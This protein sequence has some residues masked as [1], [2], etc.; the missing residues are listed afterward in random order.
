[1]TFLTE[2]SFHGAICFYCLL[3]AEPRR[4]PGLS[5]F[6]GSSGEKNRK[7]VKK[8]LLGVVY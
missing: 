7:G 3:F 8:R 5:F 2:S 1:M 4:N 6:W